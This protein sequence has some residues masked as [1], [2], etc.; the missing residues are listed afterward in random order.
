MTF[1]LIA[2]WDTK[3]GNTKAETIVAKTGEIET[4]D[5]PPFS[6]TCVCSFEYIGKIRTSRQR[7]D[8]IISGKGWNPSYNSCVFSW[9]E[10]INN[11]SPPDTLVTDFRI[12]LVDIASLDKNIDSIFLSS[13]LFSDNLIATFSKASNEKY[14]TCKFDPN[15]KG[16]YTKPK[17]WTE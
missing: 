13:K 4:D 9:G 1:F 11:E 6:D 7:F 17:K 10:L 8:L 16:K 5:G 14:M 15:R 2:C 12:H 3:K